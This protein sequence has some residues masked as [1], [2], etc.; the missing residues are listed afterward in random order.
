[1]AKSKPWSRP[2]LEKRPAR[3]LHRHLIV[4]EDKKSGADYLRSFE[5]PRE[6]VEITIVG[7]AGNTDGLVE[8]ALKLREAAIE[9]K[10]PYAKVWCVFDRDDFPEERY[11]R[12]FEI[13]KHPDVD[14]IWCNECFEL[15][16]LL[17]F[18]FRNTAIGRAE[19]IK[20]LEKSDRL[21]SEYDKAKTPIFEILK[22]K[23]NDAIKHARMLC[24]RMTPKY[25]NP[26]TRLHVLVGRLLE[27][28]DL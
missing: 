7:G 10:E 16:Y 15:W 3:K 19:I 2:R 12:A 23:T 26:S 25:S 24:E 27:F 1:M 18:E 22:D 11:N 6:L 21:G 8:R 14:I 17:H 5:V 28:Q 20:E 13:A 4:C 9:R